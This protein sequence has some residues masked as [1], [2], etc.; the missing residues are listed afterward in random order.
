M[1]KL[2]SQINVNAVL[3]QE[4]FLNFNFYFSDISTDEMTA[5]CVIF[6]LAGFDTTSSSLTMVAYLLAQNPEVQK[7]LY[8]EV[9]TMIEKLAEQ[10]ETEIETKNIFTFF[11]YDAVNSKFPLLNAVIA[12]TQRLYPPAIF[13]ERT[14]SADVQLTTNEGTVLEL[15]AGEVVHI[16]VWSLHRDPA[17]WGEDAGEFKPERFLENSSAAL[18]NAAYLPFGAG[19]RMCIAQRMATVE[20]RLALLHLVRHFRFEVCPEKTEREVTFVNQFDINSPKAV[21][22]R[23]VKRKCEN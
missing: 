18:K 4:F 7:R 22:L 1:K 21:H 3:C 9:V 6:L 10:Q 14:A 17:Y 8:T 23:I 11:S 2:N 12:E 19:S 15:K 20:L 5:Q 16:P 13:I